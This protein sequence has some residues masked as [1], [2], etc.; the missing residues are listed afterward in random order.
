MGNILLSRFQK[1]QRPKTIEKSTAHESKSTAILLLVCDWRFSLHYRHRL[2]QQN[3]V[4]ILYLLWNDLLLDQRNILWRKNCWI[5]AFAYFIRAPCF[6][7]SKESKFTAILN[8]KPQQGQPCFIRFMQNLSCLAD[9]SSSLE[10]LV[11]L[12]FFSSY[13]DADINPEKILTFIIYYTLSKKLLIHCLKD[14][15]I[16]ILGVSVLMI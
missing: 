3:W 10:G 8:E 14:V 9:A 15:K 13:G 1:Q 4:L 5:I 7:H 11:C 2:V 12:H 16:K 6:I